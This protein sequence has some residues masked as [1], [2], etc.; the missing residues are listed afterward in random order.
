MTTDD[1]VR[2]AAVNPSL[3]DALE[4]AAAL[5]A[6]LNAVV[7]GTPGAVV[8]ATTAVLAAGHL[9]IEDVP[10]VGKTML[11]KAV[12][13][14]IGTRLARIQGH[15]DLL[16]SDITG[17]SI[18]SASSETWEFRPGPVFAHV[19]LFDELNRTPPRSQAALLEAMEERQ[20]TVDGE[21]WPLPEPHLV[22]ATQNPID[23]SGTFPLVESQMDRFLLATRLGYPDETTET[24]LALS[25]GA[26][27]SLATLSPVCTPG[28]LAAVQAAVAEVPVA[29]GVAR[30]AVAV[31]RASR[32][33]PF[34]RLGASP[35]AAIGLLAAARAARRD[36]RPG[37][38][39]SRRRESDRRQRAR[40]SPGHGRGPGRSLR[41]RDR[42]RR[43]DPRAN[44][45]A[46]ALMQGRSRRH[47][48]AVDRARAPAVRRQRVR[49]LALPERAL[50]PVAGSLLLLLVW[51]GVAHASGSG[52]VQ[53][54]GAVVAGLLLLGLVAPAFSAPGLTLIC[55]RSPT[56]AVAGS[57]VEI[58]V[59]GNRSMRCT[60]WSA[61]GGPLLLTGK[62]PAS[63]FIV[64]LAQRRHLEG[65]GAGRDRSAPG[66]A[67]V[68]TGSG[69]RAGPAAL[70]CA[71]SLASGGASFARRS[72]PRRARGRHVRPSPVTCAASA[73]TST[74]TGAAASTG[75][76]AP[77]RATS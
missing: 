50:G 70:R 10:G 1:L 45:F 40:P 34:V 73:P 76:R 46:E 39:A 62:V 44:S 19:V 66:P 47:V 31:V 54:V 4:L 63:L 32:A 37:L 77:T 21:S 58:D 53:T 38:R 23:Q 55:E 29:P 14:S 57:P 56:D 69:P 75:M 9:L 67:L 13:V 64:P 72:R 24:R 71:S 8:A 26:Q 30:Y 36:R 12:A 7:L 25:H 5:Q 52:W 48:P 49:Q 20:V 28:G 18:Y 41:S 43:G 61:R 42:G 22:L 51:A 59:V 16:P 35:R 2:E 15:P 3:D 65:H 6:N 68:V 27:P 60:P 74:A 17:V 11:A 33:D